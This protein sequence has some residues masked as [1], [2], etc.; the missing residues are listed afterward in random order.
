M[1]DVCAKVIIEI[2]TRKE[3]FTIFLKVHSNLYPV[4]EFKEGGQ[5]ESEAAQ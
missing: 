2:I 5:L 3:H 1:V 4:V